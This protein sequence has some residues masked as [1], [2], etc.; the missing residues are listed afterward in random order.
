VRILPTL[1]NPGAPYDTRPRL[2]QPSASD[3]TRSASCVSVCL[4]S[5]CPSFSIWN[6]L[7]CSDIFYLLSSAII[8][9]PL[10]IRMLLTVLFGFCCM[11]RFAPLTLAAFAALLSF[12]PSSLFFPTANIPSHTVTTGKSSLASHA[13][14]PRRSQTLEANRARRPGRL[15]SPFFAA[16]VALPVAG[17]HDIRPFEANQVAS[18]IGLPLA[19]TILC[20]SPQFLLTHF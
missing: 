13:S 11:L 17:L 2:H 18:K 19:P 15:G 16:L 14:V 4:P 7:H 20:T 1:R 8:A 12:A 3:I 10:N 5:F 6:F 9:I